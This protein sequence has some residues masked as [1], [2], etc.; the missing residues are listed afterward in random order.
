MKNKFYLLLLLLISILT[1]NFQCGKPIVTVPYDHTFD[2]PVGIYPLQKT[3]TLTDTIWLETDVTGKILYDTKTSQ[4][5]LSDT[6]QISFGGVFNVF[7]TSLTNPSDG[8]CDIITKDG[9]NINRW[10]SQWGTSGSLENF[11]CSDTSYRCKI[12]FK[13]NHTGTYWLV[14]SS[15]NLGSCFDKIIPYYSS[16]NYHYKS[17]DLNLDVLNTV[18]DND[19]GGRQNR[20]WYTDRILKREIFVFRVQ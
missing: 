13:P 12:G 14:L 18:S 11:G 10:N 19:L 15:C 17:V 9:V 20:S 3:Y 5:I 1:M 4:Y 8:F 7:G 2:I 16:I 6:G